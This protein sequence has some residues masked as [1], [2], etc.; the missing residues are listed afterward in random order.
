MNMTQKKEGHELKTIKRHLLRDVRRLTSPEGYLWAGYPHFKTLFGRDTLISAWQLLKYDPGIA[1]ATL[2]NLAKYQGKRVNHKK[3]E[4]PGKILHEHR[5]PSEIRRWRKKFE[6]FNY[7]G[8]PYYGSADSTLWFIIVA[9]DYLKYT[10][11]STTIKKLWPNIKK[12]IEWTYKYGDADGDGFIEYERK[13]PAGLYHQGWRDSPENHLKIK[14]PVALVEIQGYAYRA[15]EVGSELATLEGESH[16]AR[17]L[18]RRAQNLKQKFDSVFWDGSRYIL[19]LDKHK[20][21]DKSSSSNQG[22]LLFTGIIPSRKKEQKL[23]RRLFSPDMWTPYGIRT[24]SSKDKHFNEHSY[25]LGSVWPH[26]NWIIYKGLKDHGYNAQ[27]QKIKQALLNAFVEI[28]YLPEFYIVK[29]NKIA[30]PYLRR[31]CHPQA[32][33]TAAL[34]EM[35]ADD[36]NS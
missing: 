22:H 1:K 35:I 7:W 28:G 2:V 19:A 6:H 5:S 31:A 27:V 21:K 20:K 30:R 14:S 29:N 3:E 24:L 33:A 16:L 36:T 23:I 13:N 18:N 11:D 12:A 15:L 34:L 26:D 8:F 9:C 10:N 17:E 25:H 4:E 32:W